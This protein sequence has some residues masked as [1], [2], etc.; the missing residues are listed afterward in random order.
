[1][2]RWWRHRWPP[3]QAV[4]PP[5]VSS[6]STRPTRRCSSII[7]PRRPL[8]PRGA[9]PA[10]AVVVDTERSAFASPSRPPPST[11]LR[12]SPSTVKC[13]STSTRL[14]QIPAPMVAPLERHSNVSKSKLVVHTSDLLSISSARNVHHIVST[15]GFSNVRRLQ[16]LLTSFLIVFGQSIEI[17]H[18]TKYKS[19]LLYIV[20]CVNA[21]NRNQKK[22]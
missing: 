12:T 15:F 7:K 4:A 5:E 8:R 14:S 20:N 11:S 21:L 18:Q 17:N 22:R 9:A 1:M 16:L 10:P 19:I 13:L 2:R 6:T 3:S